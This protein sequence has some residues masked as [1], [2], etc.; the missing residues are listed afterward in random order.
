MYV[1]P[2]KVTLE[3]LPAIDWSHYGAEAAD[4]DEVLRACYDEITG[5]MQQV[6]DRLNRE[7]PHPITQ[8]TVSLVGKAASAPL[9]MDVRSVLGCP[10]RTISRSA[11]MLG[12]AAGL[13]DRQA[14]W[15]QSQATRIASQGRQ[16][17]IPSD[18]EPPAP[19]TDDDTP[20]TVQ[21]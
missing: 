16:P 12:G 11:G 4:D 19:V 13:L 7:R 9:R 17:T 14:G 20:P 15:L 5:K 18:P 1:L 3:F 8:G 21:P 2:S 6:L 10:V